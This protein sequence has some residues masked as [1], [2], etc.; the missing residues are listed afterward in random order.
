MQ[1]LFEDKENFNDDISKWDVRNVVNMEY[2]FYNASQLNQDLS[3]Q[4]V[5]K[6]TNMREMFANCPISRRNKPKEKH[7][8]YA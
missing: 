3:S 2:M 1:S 7:V 5:S 6:V 4:N 8:L